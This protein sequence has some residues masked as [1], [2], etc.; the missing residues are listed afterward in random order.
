MT[1]EQIEKLLVL[2]DSIDGSLAVMADYTEKI[3][4]RFEE[5]TYVDENGVCYIKVLSR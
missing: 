2:L 4:L 5:A 3:A 1:H